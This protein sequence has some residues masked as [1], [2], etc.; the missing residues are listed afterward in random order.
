MALP[1]DWEVCDSSDTV[2]PMILYLLS[3]A[4]RSS[5]LKLLE[6]GIH[7]KHESPRIPNTP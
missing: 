5:D 4:Q 6:L 7:G 1:P 2:G 3:C